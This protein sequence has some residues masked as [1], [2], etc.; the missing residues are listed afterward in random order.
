[1]ETISILKS[2][3]PRRIPIEGTI[4]VAHQPECIPWLGNISKATMGDV[5]FI[6]DTVQFVKKHWQNKNKIRIKGGEGFQWLTIPVHDVQDHR[7]V[8]NEVI[9]VK[10]DWRKSI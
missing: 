2:Q 1:M 10:G 9:L 7:S 3:D 5:Y 8:T 6:L 4:L